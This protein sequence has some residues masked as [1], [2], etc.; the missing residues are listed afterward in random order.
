MMM[1]TDFSV[2]ALPIGVKFCTAVRPH[3]GQVFSHVGG[4]A[5]GWPNFGRQQGAIWRDMLLVEELVIVII[6]FILF[7]FCFYLAYK[8]T[9]IISVSLC[10]CRPDWRTNLLIKPVN[11]ER[12]PET[13]S[14]PLS[15]TPSRIIRKFPACSRVL[16]STST[17]NS[18]RDRR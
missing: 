15:R 12:R 16:V 8:L 17:R 10:L 11:G 14:A 7:T 6:F 2:G 3:L 5:P 4:T 18:S 1:V 9:T 13:C